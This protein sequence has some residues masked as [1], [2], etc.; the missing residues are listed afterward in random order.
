MSRAS[1]AIST[2]RGG[3]VDPA[4]DLAGVQ[5]EHR[6]QVQPAFAGWDVGEVGQPDL[7]G[8]LGLEV[9]AEPVGRDRIAVT[10]VSGA[11]PSGQGRPA[12]QTGSA[13]QP[14]DARASDPAA[15]AAQ[16]G[17]HPRRAVGPAALG[18]DLPNVLDQRPVGGRP[19]ALRP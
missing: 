15:M 11:G 3:R 14:L 17:M 6:G 8:G 5:I 2:R 19:R 12:P 18:M 10:A 1:R 9:A 16:H 7:V 4:G 13:H